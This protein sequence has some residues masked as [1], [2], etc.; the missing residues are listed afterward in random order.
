MPDVRPAAPAESYA[1]PAPVVRGSGAASTCP[2]CGAPIV[3]PWCAACGEQDPAS[4]R[5]GV[6]EFVQDAVEAA[7][8]ADGTLWRSLRALV[9]RPGELALAYV[10]G[11]R[12]RYFSPLRLFLIANVVYF[13]WASAVGD[14]IF[15]T[16]LDTQITNT[17]HRRVARPL[18]AARIEER[19]IPYWRY[20][21]AFNRVSDTQARTLVVTMVPGF[22]L[23]VAG[24]QRRRRRWFAQ[25]LAFAF[26]VYAWIL[27]LCIVKDY[28]FD[29]PWIAL[30]RAL[31]LPLSAAWVYDYVPSALLAAAIGVHLH[32]ALRR[33]YGDG[34]LAA[35]AKAVLLAFVV[36]A[37]IQ[38]YRPLLFLAA[39][40]TT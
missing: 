9:L 35:A 40:W 17:L 20:R 39:Y 11:D 21:D 22:A 38:L 4:R 3:A 16:T 36:V 5:L 18:V 8:N 30:A 29:R 1:P 7:T 28:A 23:A 25:D 26:H 15:T 24:L 31:D 32:C 34:R 19:G 2:G 12:K 10:R 37:L 6:R 14:H 27:L 33:A 13:V